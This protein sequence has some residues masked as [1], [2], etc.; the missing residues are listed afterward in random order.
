MQDLWVYLSEQSEFTFGNHEALVWHETNIPYAV[1]TADSVRHKNFTYY[2]SEAV[3]RNGTLY[4]YV[5]FARSGFSPDPE[6]PDYVR[7]ATFSRRHRKYF[8]YQS[9]LHHLS[10]R[11]HHLSFLWSWTPFGHKGFAGMTFV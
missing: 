7:S 9:H 11:F 2:P 4:A 5:F 1:W 3:Q 8:K 6:S 10:F